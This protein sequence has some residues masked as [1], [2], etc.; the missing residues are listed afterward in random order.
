MNLSVFTQLYLRKLGQL[1]LH[2]IKTQ[3]KIRWIINHQIF[4]LV[5][6]QHMVESNEKLSYKNNISMYFD[7]FMLRLMQA[8]KEKRFN[9]RSVI[10]C[11]SNTVKPFL[12]CL[13]RTVL[14]FLFA[15]Q[16]PLPVPCSVPIQMRSD[17]KMRIGQLPCSSYPPQ[18][19]LCLT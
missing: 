7:N 8:S 13:T 9:L 2:Y 19:A 14:L 12:Q 3:R 10:L 4:C 1:F 5:C 11:P 6:G 16:V 17:K 18:F 15:V